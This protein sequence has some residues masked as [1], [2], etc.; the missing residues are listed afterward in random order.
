MPREPPAIG[1]VFA[2]R[3]RIEGILGRGGMGVVL[4]A[5]HVHLDETVAI[6]LIS[7][8]AAASEDAVPRFLREARAAVKIRSEHVVKVQDVATLDDG[9]AYMVM[10]LL[11]GTDLSTRLK[12]RGPL[13]LAEAIDCALQV[14]AALEVA[15]AQ[16]FVHRDLKPANLFLTARADGTP[17]LKVLDF[18]ISKLAPQNAVGSMTTTSATMGPQPTWRPSRCARPATSTH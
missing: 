5:R 10:E 17:L 6:K 3:Y 18:G 12:T 2:G 14:C 7:P 13:P 9:T 4:A 16:G 11:T 1:T 8:D 15:H